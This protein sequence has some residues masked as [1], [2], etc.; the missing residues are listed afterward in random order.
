MCW[1]LQD[2]KRTGDLTEVIHRAPYYM[3]D[4]AEW[5]DA[6]KGQVNLAWLTAKWVDY[7]CPNHGE[8]SEQETEPEIELEEEK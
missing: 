4:G 1:V 5:W 2:M 3:Y 6:K 7:Q 8:V